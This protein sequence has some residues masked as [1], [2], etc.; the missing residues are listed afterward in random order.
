MGIFSSWKTVATAA[1]VAAVIPAVSASAQDWPKSGATVTIVNP[2]PP[3]STADTVARILADKWQEK[4]GN[5]FIVENRAGASGNIGQGYVARQAPDG[6]T[7]IITTPGPA[8]NNKNTFENLPFDPLTDFTSIAQLY[9][10]PLIM[11][12]NK[13]F[14]PNN[15]QELI[16]YAK[17]NPGKVNA[18]HPGQGTYAHMALLTSSDLA[19]IELNLVPYRGGGPLLPDLIGG[20]VQIAMDLLGTY[21]PGIQA[22]Q[23]KLLGVA[24]TGRDKTFPEIATFQEQGV[25]FSAAAWVAFQGPKGMDPEVVKKINA[26][27]VEFMNN[28]QKVLELLAKGAAYPATTTPERM[29]E[30]IIEEEAKWR[31]TIRK[32]NIRSQ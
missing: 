21:V 4:Y 2:W 8:A 26:D 15:L 25:N 22:G 7:L 18:G 28:D 17:A 31:E 1:I 16:A 32:Y 12:A 10:T 6:N 20:Q 23:L 9:E 30:I 24:T 13:D 27:I 14:P 5:T 11:V 3:G 29:A 19:G